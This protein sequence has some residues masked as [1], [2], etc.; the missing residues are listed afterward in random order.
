MLVAVTQTVVAISLGDAEFDALPKCSVELLAPRA[1]L[2]KEKNRNQFSARRQAQ[3]YAMLTSSR[4]ITYGDAA[5]RHQ[6]EPR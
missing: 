4:N 2:E 5:E 6:T 1:A 3:W